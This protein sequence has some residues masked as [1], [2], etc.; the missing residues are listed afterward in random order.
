MIRE[1]LKNSPRLFDLAK[2][3]SRACGHRTELNRFL[4]RLLPRNE[5]VSFLQA[6]ANDGITNDPYRE[7][8]LQ[9]NFC[10][11]LVEPSPYPFKKLQ[12]AY[13]HKAGLHYEACLVSY[14]AGETVDF[15]SFDESFLAKRADASHLSMLSSLSEEQLLQA[16]AGQEDCRRHI[17]KTQLTGRTIEQLMMKHGYTGFDCLFIDIEGYEPRVLLAMDYALVRPK[18]IAFESLHLGSAQAEVRA[19][20]EGQGFRL[21]EFNHEM[22]ALGRAWWPRVQA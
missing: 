6:G 20:L 2:A 17:V 12:A 16:V 19:H 15:F 21:Y 13:R 14:P 5:A 22:I 1:Y 4:H 11:V 9:P 10:G 8:I 7:F 18:L 3:A